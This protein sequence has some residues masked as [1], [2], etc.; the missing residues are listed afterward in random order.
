MEASIRSVRQASA[1]GAPIFGKFHTHSLVARQ[2]SDRPRNARTPVLFGIFGYGFCYSSPALK[3]KICV[4][5][6]RE[7]TPTCQ[8]SPNNQP[9]CDLSR[10]T[11]PGR[12]SSTARASRARAVPQK[13]AAW[14]R[15]SYPRTPPLAVDRARWVRSCGRARRISSTAWIVTEMGEST[16]TS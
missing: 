10:G 7:A 4:R 3:K 5:R 9:G 16:C 13:W 2:F 6:S 12:A 11:V 1:R 14:R 8:I 15:R